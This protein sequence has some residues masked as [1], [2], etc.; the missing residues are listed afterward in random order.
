MALSFASDLLATYFDTNI[1]NDANYETPGNFN[2]PT[3]MSGALGVDHVTVNTGGTYTTVPTAT[4]GSG[5]ATFQTQMSFRS[6]STIAAAG[7]GYAPGD[8]V[9][10]VGGT[11]V[12]PVSLT[13]ATCKLVSATINAGGTGYG[14][15]QTFTVTVAGGTETVAATISVTTNS[16]GVVTTVNSI[17]AAGSYTVLPTLTANAVTG[18]DGTDHGTGLTMNLVFGVNTFTVGTAGFYTALPA[19][20]I[21]TTTSGSGT[22]LTFTGSWTVGAVAVTNAGVYDTGV[23]PTVNFSSGSA[24]ATAVLAT[25]STTQTDQQKMLL[26]IEIVRSFI[27]EADSVAQLRDMHEIMRK[28]MAAIKYGASTSASGNTNNFSASTLAT[29]ALNAAM[30]YFAGN[31]KRLN[32]GASNGTPRGITL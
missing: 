15:A 25:A 28:M 12:T 9:S 6:A 1:G 4:A 10:L 32:V 20:P 21:A 23:A 2:I 26:L 11:A 14:N 31:P 5:A 27:D 16:S 17:S 13:V 19:N 7:T 22:G 29:N 3:V 24:T 8:T 18:D 30:T